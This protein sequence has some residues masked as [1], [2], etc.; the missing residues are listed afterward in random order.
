MGKKELNNLINFNSPI[1]DEDLNLSHDEIM[2][3][4][5]NQTFS[6][7]YDIFF[8]KYMKYLANI[9]GIHNMGNYYKYMNIDIDEQTYD[10]IITFSPY[11]LIMSIANMLNCLK[12]AG[13]Y[14]SFDEIGNSIEK[15]N[16]VKDE[17]ELAVK[18]PYLYQY[19]YLPN[20]QRAIKNNL[21]T[22]IFA[23][24]NAKKDFI[25][26]NILKEEYKKIGL[27]LEVEYQYAKSCLDFKSFIQAATSH[28]FA[29]ITNFD[30]I[31]KWIRE[32]PIKIK[33]H[34]TEIK[35]IY[36]YILYREIENMIRYA[37]NDLKQEAQKNVIII[38]NLI[39]KYKSMFPNDT[40]QIRFDRFLDIDKNI[41]SNEN[42]IIMTADFNKL[43][44]IFEEF[45][46]RF[47]FLKRNVEL[48]QINKGITYQDAKT[49]VNNYI[50]SI[51]NDTI[52]QNLSNGAREIDNK[53]VDE[54]VK[55]IENDIQSGTLS[56]KE[57]NV[58]KLI[59]KKIKMVLID[60]KPT[61]KQTGIGVFSSYYTYFYPNGMVAIDKLSGYG[62]LYIMPIHIYKEARYKKNLT[63][64]RLISGVKY[65]THRSE[66]WLEEAKKYILNGTSNLSEKDI[67]DAEFVASINFPYTIEEMEKLQ[68][69]L[70]NSGQYTSQMKEET[71]KRKE[72][73]QLLIDI[74]RELTLSDE[75]SSELSKEEFDE[76]IDKLNEEELL[77]FDEL[78]QY[79]KQNHQGVKVKRNPVVA[80]ITKNRARDENGNYCCE[81]CGAKNFEHSAFDSHHMIP[82][83]AGGV[84]NI[85]NTVCL[86]PNCHRY[87]H[88]GKMTLYQQHYMFEII[89]NH[90][91]NDNPEY[92]VQLDKMISPIAES[93]EHYREHKDEIDHN[94]SILW[95]GNSLKPR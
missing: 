31:K 19:V 38:E 50:E 46:V 60:I 48:P 3:V 75:Q 88:S 61:A 29:L 24:E 41:K 43:I 84:D 14:L 30:S 63:E 34:S 72:K 86:C 4:L 69:S 8:K 39:R 74:D 76:E 82:L 10:S 33:L 73:I 77:T 9:S 89:K 12:K 47:S 58:K 55:E 52:K 85:Y 64:V 27:D 81:L 78:Y 68:K 35:K 79:W 83:S 5:N 59:L 87:I 53:I 45:A 20:R 17:K 23:Y 28:F 95:N 94:F 42:P 25:Q 7:Q 90:I 37:E 15:L 44:N 65:V 21:G 6:K 62:A 51:L 93:D 26:F 66:N 67:H 11:G 57:L 54:Q 22:I 32:N 91:A 18:F 71:E 40:T 13:E 92:L 70:E 36:L 1:M 56:E 49:F 16:R 80:M 2:S